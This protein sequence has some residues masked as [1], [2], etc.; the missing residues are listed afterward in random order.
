MYQLDELTGSIKESGGN[1]TMKDVMF[2]KDFI[3]SLHYSTENEIFFGNVESID[4]F[5]LV[6]KVAVSKS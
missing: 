1:L 6:L 3:G 5:R 4:D 2:Y